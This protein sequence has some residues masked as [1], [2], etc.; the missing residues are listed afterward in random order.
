MAGSSSANMRAGLGVILM[1]SCHQLECFSSQPFAVCALQFLNTS[2]E[3]LAHIVAEVMEAVDAH[4][5]ML[6]LH[7]SN[8][9]LP[10]QT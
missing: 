10:A 5:R 9:D 4:S 2:T 7:Q 3:I 1:G 6:G 8:P